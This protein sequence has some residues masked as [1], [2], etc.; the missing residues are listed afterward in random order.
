[1]SKPLSTFLIVMLSFAAAIGQAKN[2]RARANLL[3]AVRTVKEAHYRYSDSKPEPRD[4]VTYDVNGNEIERVMISDFGEL[5][6]KQIQKFDTAGLIQE[7]VF[8]DAKGN[9]KERSMYEFTADKLTQ[10]LTY[11]SKNILREKTARK[12]NAS[13]EFVEE[14]YFDPTLERAKTIFKY[15]EKG[16]AIEMAFFMRDGQ[17]AIAPVGPCLGGHRVTFTYDKNNRPIT[18]TVFDAKENIKKT[19]AYSYD[20]NGNII[21]YTVKSGSNVTKISYTYEYDGKGNWTKQTAVT[22]SEYD[23]IFDAMLKA[24]GKTI[25]EEERKRA[26]KEMKEM[27]TRRT[28]SARQISYY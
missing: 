11:D 27:T 17:K 12:Y 10:V 21:V 26:E 13:G 7:T 5:I 20:S 2:D 4:T 19:W 16:N 28:V 1:M 8:S 22:E 15:D 3:G 25:T 9:I 14:V 6:G 24:T 23:G 18:K